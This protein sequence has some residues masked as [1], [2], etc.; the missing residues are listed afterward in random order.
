MNSLSSRLRAGQGEALFLLAYLPSLMPLF[1]KYMGAGAFYSVL[2]FFKPDIACGHHLCYSIARAIIYIA[3]QLGIK[4]GRRLAMCRY[5]ANIVDSCP[6]SR[7]S[8]GGHYRVGVLPDTCYSGPIM[9]NRI[10][11]VWR[12]AMS[13]RLLRGGIL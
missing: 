5:L 11:K 7:Y 12:L 1:L 9:S 2:A 8:G 6:Y 4:T 10:L 3:A 13:Q